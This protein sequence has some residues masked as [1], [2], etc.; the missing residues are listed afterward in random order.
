[1]NSPE[2]I[3]QGDSFILTIDYA[4]DS[5]RPSRVFRAMSELIEGFQ[6]LDNDLVRAFPVRVE[7]ELIL[8]DIQVGSLRTV[9][10]N[11]LKGMDD[12]ALKNLEWKKIV[13]G[14]LLQGKHAVLKWIEAREQIESRKA[15]QDLSEEVRRL[16]EGTRI[17]HL[18][19]YTPPPLPL[20]VKD[21]GVIS[22]AVA[23]LG[24]EDTASYEAAGSISGFNKAFHVDQEFAEELLTEETITNKSEVLLRVKKPDYLGESMWEFEHA[25]H[26]IRARIEDHDW[27][28]S[29]QFQKVEVRPGDSLRVIL[30]TTTHHGSEGE[31][32]VTYYRILTVLNVRRASPGTQLELPPGN[33]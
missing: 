30:E 3:E 11:T 16:A 6:A 9:I 14:F 13:G 21:I 17:L 24:T 4:K 10:K 20:L 27:L 15:L 28:V 31:E 33:V 18:P 22:I 2:H 32:L 25:G 23:N 8:E 29:F 5:P 7:S 19:I 26:I 12:A 1:M